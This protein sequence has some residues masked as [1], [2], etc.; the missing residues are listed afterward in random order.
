[1]ATGGWHKAFWPNT[2]M[3]DLSG[4]G[5]AMAHRPG[6]ELGNMKF[7]TFCCNVLL[8]PPPWRGSIATY[9]LGLRFDAEITN[10]AGEAFLKKYDPFVVKTGTSMERNKGFVSFAS[11][12]EMRDGK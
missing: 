12:R 10:S 11:M 8:W 7:I 5:I 2:A 3:R 4:E 6:V 9:I 1:M